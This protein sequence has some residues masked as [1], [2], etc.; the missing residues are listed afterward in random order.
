MDRMKDF[1]CQATDLF[2]TKSVEC[3]TD[4]SFPD[5][6]E[7]VLKCGGQPPIFSTPNWC[8]SD[9]VFSFYLMILLFFVLLNYF[10]K[11]VNILFHS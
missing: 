8:G 6:P 5:I 9:I 1:A 3:Q 11:N 10:I 2:E 4:I 7:V